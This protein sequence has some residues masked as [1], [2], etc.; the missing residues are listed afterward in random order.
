MT[1]HD[2]SV[3]AVDQ[4]R[5]DRLRHEMA[6]AGIDA[7]FLRLPEN[8]LYVSGFW[9]VSGFCAAL[10][11]R[12]GDTTLFV[13]LGEDEYATSAW[14]S[15]VRTFPA[16]SL[17]S[18]ASY[19]E[20]M[21]PAVRES[22]RARRL[23]SAMIGYEG[24]FDLVA[25]A[26]WQGEVRVVAA[27]TVNLLWSV[28]SGASL[29]DATPL[30]RQA[31]ATKSPREIAAMRRAS[32]VAIRGLAAG[33]E[34]IAP[35]TSEIEVALAIQSR[36]ALE[37]R[38]LGPSAERTGGFATVMSGPLA[39]NACR[40]FDISTNRRLAPG[41]LLTIELGAYCDG[42]W[43]DLTRT[44]V[45]GEPD[46]RQ[47][48][49][50]ELV[51]RAQ[52][53]AIARMRPG[54]LAREVDAAARAVIGASGYGDQF[55]HGLGHAVGLQWH[56]PP[57]LHPASDHVLA[58]GEVYTIEPGIYLD[59]WGGIRVEDVVAVGPNGGE[60]LSPYD[61]GLVAREGHHGN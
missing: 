29:R 1:D 31:R 47:R 26:H 58:E 20:L 45:V 12:D 38:G 54:A 8:I 43:S 49:V 33:R 23:A 14:T 36:I 51:V 19:Y 55:P 22:I 53:A 6:A 46:A 21:A 2:A 52:E 25:T 57:A 13:P 39:A 15:D 41:D 16:G 42:Y 10:V 5:V 3:T 48:A 9:P 4:V 37:A 61:R 35:G 24:S 17:A 28:A 40:H 27:P 7:L 32:E 11:T 56:E 60:N 59:G 50:H 34:V 18:T 44:Y 30:L